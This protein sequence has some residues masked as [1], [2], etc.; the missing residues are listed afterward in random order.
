MTVFNLLSLLQSC[1]P[2]LTS[3]KQQSLVIGILAATHTLTLF[4]IGNHRKCPSLF[5]LQDFSGFRL[6]LLYPRERS[7][8]PA[9]TQHQ[10]ATPRAHPI[11]GAPKD[12][13]PALQIKGKPLSAA[14]IRSGPDYLEVPFVATHEAKRGRGYGKC[15]V[16]AIEEIARAL[17]MPR[18]LLCSTAEEPVQATWHHLG[19]HDTSEHQLEGW[20]VQDTD[21][22]HMQNTVQMH[23]EVPPPRRW[24]P[25]VIRHQAYIS[26]IYVAL[27][28]APTTSKSGLPGPRPQQGAVSGFGFRS[29]ISGLDSDGGGGT[30]SL[31]T[32]MTSMRE[33][34]DLGQTSRRRDPS[35][36]AEQQQQQ[37]GYQQQQNVQLSAAAAGGVGGAA[38][39]AQQ[40][41]LHLVHQQQ[42]QHDPGPQ[43]G[44]Q[45]EEQQQEQQQPMEVDLR[46][47]HAQ[48]QQQSFA[49]Q[50]LGGQGVNFQQLSAAGGSP[51]LAV[52]G[53][54]Q[55]TAA[56]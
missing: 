9:P 27:D 17:N 6:L 45:P 46:P 35:V 40:Q 33:D 13:W 25:L 14:T 36:E 20:G 47:Q 24:K 28:Q 34:G 2:L 29:S 38:L 15:V 12:P 3:P 50:P 44:H 37:Q 21:L 8:W 7:C 49:G 41:Q 54:L 56:S 52:A 19:F 53:T 30:A 48:Q 42:Q 31:M 10:K 16:E 5:L 26:R 23:K 4:G 18:L 55:A 51:T 11:L 43:E 39:Q 1:M 32:G 22:V